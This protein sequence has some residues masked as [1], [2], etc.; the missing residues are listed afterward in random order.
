MERSITLHM[1]IRAV[2]VVKA[3][4]LALGFGVW[5]RAIPHHL[6][7]TD[8][9][10]SSIP[11]KIISRGRYSC[12][13]KFLKG[14]RMPRAGLISKTLKELLERVNSH[15]IYWQGDVENISSI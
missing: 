6:T 12:V 8:S 2:L 4:I 7:A 3:V 11:S 9:L 10:V 13:Y 1:S 14:A 15:W 5:E